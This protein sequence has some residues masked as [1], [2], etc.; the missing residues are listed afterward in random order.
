MYA[1]NN[2]PTLIAC[3]RDEPMRLLALTL[4]AGFV[5]GLLPR[6]VIRS[7]LGLAGPSLVYLGVTKVRDFFAAQDADAL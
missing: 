4:A 1:S 5:I 7:A 6:R 3:L 2:T